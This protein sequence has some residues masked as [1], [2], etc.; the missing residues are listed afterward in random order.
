MTTIE[1]IASHMSPD[2]LAVAAVLAGDDSTETLHAARREIAAYGDRLRGRNRGPAHRVGRARL[3]AAADAA[4]D[5]IAA[6][7]VARGAL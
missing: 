7:L 1:T 2:A 6:R 4:Y 5:E 3:V